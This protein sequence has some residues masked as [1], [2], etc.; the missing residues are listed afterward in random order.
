MTHLVTETAENPLAGDTEAPVAPAQAQ[1]ANVAVENDALPPADAD[2][3]AG[4]ADLDGV[5]GAAWA[6]S[7]LKA[8]AA[9]PPD[10]LES[11]LLSHLQAMNTAYVEIDQAAEATRDTES[12]HGKRCKALLEDIDAAVERLT[13]KFRRLAA[14][15]DTAVLPPSGVGTSSR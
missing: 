2:P 5:M 15:K 3:S 8:T 7:K 6:A 1:T 11:S 10:Q 4:D 13:E 12:A 14:D 9:H